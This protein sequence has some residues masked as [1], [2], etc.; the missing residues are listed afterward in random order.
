MTW[1]TYD[2]SCPSLPYNM[3]C[4]LRGLLRLTYMMVFRVLGYCTG[5]RVYRLSGRVSAKRLETLNP[6]TIKR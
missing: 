2:S 5:F 6:Q 4:L 3:A 1:F